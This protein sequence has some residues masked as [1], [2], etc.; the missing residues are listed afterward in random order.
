MTDKPKNPRPAD[1]G[2]TEDA[3]K[4]R[5]DQLDQ[6]NDP[7]SEPHPGDGTNTGPVAPEY[8]KQW[9]VTP[10]PEGDDSVPAFIQDLEGPRTE[11]DENAPTLEDRAAQAAEPAKKAQDAKKK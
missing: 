11:A 5:Q 3:D 9:G 2:F 1:E 6:R 10:L 4:V 8:G 7:Q